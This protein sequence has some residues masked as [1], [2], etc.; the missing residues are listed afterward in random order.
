MKKFIRALSLAMALLM[1]LTIALVGCSDKD[2]DGDKDGKLD[3]D[4]S[5]LTKKDIKDLFKDACKDFVK[6][7]S[8]E[9]DYVT[10]DE[11]E[12]ITEHY[13]MDKDADGNAVIYYESKYSED[14]I[15]YFYLTEKYE[16]AK[17]HYEDRVARYENDEDLTVEFLLEIMTLYFED[18]FM[19]KLS[20]VDLD[21]KKSGSDYVFEFKSEDLLESFRL[22]SDIEDDEDDFMQEMQ[23]VEKF[24]LEIKITLDAYGFFKNANARIYMKAGE[25]ESNETAS[26]TVV[27]YNDGSIKVEEPDWVKSY[28]DDDDDNNEYPSNP[29]NGGDNNENNNGNNNNN[30]NNDGNGNVTVTK[31]NAEDML[32][33]ACD[34][35]GKINSLAFTVVS[36]YNGEIENDLTFARINGDGK[37]AVYTENDLGNGS[38]E[39][40]YS[41]GLKEYA[42]YP[43]SSEIYEYNLEE[44]LTFESLIEGIYR[45]VF[46]NTPENTIEIF[47][48]SDFEVAK[49]DGVYVIALET[50]SAREFFIALMGEEA[51][52]GDMGAQIDAIS[53]FSGDIIFELYSD[54]SYKKIAF[55]YSGVI[56]GESN[57]IGCSYQF[58]K[59]DDDSIEVN[60]PEWVT[61]YKNNNSSE[62]NPDDTTQIPDDNENTGAEVSG[63]A[64]DVISNAL[65][66][67]VN[68]ETL[69]LSFEATNDSSNHSMILKS[70][71]DADGSH[72]V[73]CDC[74]TLE[75]YIDAQGNLYEYSDGEISQSYISV[76]ALEY[77]FENY[78]PNYGFTDIRDIVERMCK[79]GFTVTTQGEYTV[80]TLETDYLGFAKIMDPDV[81]ED[82]VF[83]QMIAQVKDSSVTVT[84]TVDENGTLKALSSDV[85]VN[86][87]GMSLSI[88]ENVDIILVNS[89]IK[90]TA[91]EWLANA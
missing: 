78:I 49:I 70:V 23:D 7:D 22:I 2:D 75:L 12:S 80:Y 46:G 62:E 44:E 82:E 18:G 16:Y 57:S 9:L 55:Y 3:L 73:Y 36:D 17:Y 54:G 29:D 61:D 37:L 28:K 86:L 85:S 45:F 71:K 13:L 39:Y 1:V 4:L 74:E 8:L 53:D 42:K 60:E 72:K 90:F 77:I 67:I 40:T 76:D 33:T 83:S 48:R 38:F 41:V 52:E 64:Y 50:E 58:D 21:V 69:E 35:F 5:E 66:E 43:F 34:K 27:K 63:D 15:D 56:D 6:A 91:P 11:N 26:C 31:E 68:S 25:Y 14:E 51:L 24:S 84:Y 32:K 47:C 81:M 88:D 30:D 10:G 87:E 19:E 89:L 79:I 59:Y 65:K 20:Q